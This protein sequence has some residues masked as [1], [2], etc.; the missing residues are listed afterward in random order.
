MILDC[1][2]SFFFFNVTGF[3]VVLFIYNYFEFLFI[4]GVHSCNWRMKRLKGCAQNAYR[5]NQRHIQQR[6]SVTMTALELVVVVVNKG[7]RGLRSNIK[8]KLE[9][10]LYVYYRLVVC[11]S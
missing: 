6:K 7:A 2:L 3:F 1:F 11:T 4:A 10:S 5:G 9:T 8:L